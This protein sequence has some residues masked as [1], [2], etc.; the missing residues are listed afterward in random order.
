VCK[1]VWVTIEKRKVEKTKPICTLQVVVVTAGN[2]HNDELA[3]I[4]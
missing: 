4:D 1:E 2:I 3:S